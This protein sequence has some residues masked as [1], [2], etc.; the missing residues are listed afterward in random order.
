MQAIFLSADLMFTSR[1]ESAAA[2]LGFQLSS[3]A[4][5]DRCVELGDGEPIE[6]FI[7][8]LT[9]RGC[10]SAGV[11]EAVSQHWPDAALLAFGPHVHEANLAAAQA[12][13]F[14]EVLTRGQFN[15]QLPAILQKYLQR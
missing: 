5:L 3:A 6:L 15:A 4:T 12:A 1:V 2:Q 7:F 13:G 8:D 14:D 9:T 11:A 10:E